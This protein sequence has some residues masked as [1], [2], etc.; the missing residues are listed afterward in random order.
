MMET[1]EQKPI[2]IKEVFQVPNRPTYAFSVACRIAHAVS[3]RLCCRRYLKAFPDTVTVH[4][5]RIWLQSANACLVSLSGLARGC[6]EKL[7]IA[8]FVRGLSHAEVT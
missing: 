2:S 5:R 8:A 6:A 1:S 4:G 3:S 7:E